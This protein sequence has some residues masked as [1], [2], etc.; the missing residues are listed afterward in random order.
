MDKQSDNA[1]DYKSTLNLP[2]TDFPMKANLP[3]REPEWLKRWA[4][5]D[6]YGRIRKARAGQPRFVLQDGPPY[7]N[8]DIHIGHAVN[9]VL[10]DIVVKSRSLEGMDA[11]YIPGWDC[12]GLPIELMVEK[13][14]GK[15]GQK[16]DAK[17]F[18]AACRDYAREQVS[19]Q[20][21]DFKRLGILGDWEKPYLTMDFAYE[22]N[23]LR[24][25]SEVIKRGH[26]YKGLKPVY[27]C[28][29]C[30]S[31]LAEAEV[32]Y[33]DKTS[34]AVDVRFP[35]ADEADLLKRVHGAAG[36]GP[37]SLV[38]WTTTPWT[39]PANQAVALNGEIEYALVQFTSDRGMERVLLAKPLVEAVMQRWGIQDFRIV[40]QAMGAALEGAKLRHPF[41]ERQVPVILG[42]HVTLDAGTGAVH[43]A[44][45]HGQEDFAV[46]QKY[47]LPVENPVDA[48]G[49]YLP[50]TRLFAGQHVFKANDHIVKLLAEQG[51]LLFHEA[52]RH[53]YPHCWRHKSPVIFRATPQWFI[54]MDQKGLRA[55]AMADIQKVQWMPDWGQNR[56]EAM[57]ANRPDWCISRQRTWGVP[58][59][60]FVHKETG[61]LHPRTAELLEQAAER[62]EE[63][64]VDAWFDLDAK[65]LLGDEA[66][67]YDK[68]RDILDVWFD[69]GVVHYCVGEKRLGLGADVSADLYLEGSDQH[70]GWFQSSL[71]TSVAIHGKAPYKAV[72]THGFTVDEQ[73]RKMSKSL[74]NTVVPQKVIGSL[75]ADVL[76]LWVAATDYSGE[77]AISDNILKHMAEAYRKMRNTTRYLLANLYD[78]D[79]ARHALPAEKMLELDRWLLARAAEL[80]VEVLEAYRNY[81][82]HLI[83]QKVYGFCVVDLS[84]FYLDVIKDREYTTRAD[85]VARRSC[86]TA[87]YHVAEAMVRWLAP[88]L[89]FTAEEIWH[90]LPGKREASVFLA[91]WHALPGAGKVDM[92]RWQQVLAVR[93]A[94]RKELEKL[95][96]AGAIGSSLDAEVDLYC[97]PELMQALGSLGDELRFALITSYARVH[98]DEPRPKDA[99]AGEEREG[100][101]VKV[102][103]SKHTKCVRC[104]HHREDVGADKKHPELCGRCVTNVDGPG[105]TRRFA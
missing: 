20:R 57:V 22:G 11:P 52:Y 27:W 79:P 99:V 82:F 61:E 78:F 92:R 74:G 105:E 50:S 83:Y 3:G 96:V 6:L 32:E 70:R 43:T 8:G 19:R 31:A 72:L 104:W 9:K 15:A 37:V 90:F 34:P 33:E 84:S 42:E 25:L 40:G 7:A 76:R 98:G 26:L 58:I 39:L 48:N 88:V 100:L 38:I 94:V 65:E 73:G 44:P 64:G 67:H 1:V 60:L 17:A 68:V 41:Y 14:V 77:L 55:A 36:Q 86:Q 69:S 21:E 80:Q 4:E 29:D 95:R 45:G 87:M 75:G 5:E 13:K 16:V 12:H 30:G 102:A 24:A 81:Q 23:Q 2:R 97:E 46:G 56:I 71:L 53:S 101:W 54:S 103:P 89:S 91:T 93:E 28:L 47:K 62:V 51:M 63:H 59:A 18:R 10:K 66:S 35:A 49:V 85:S